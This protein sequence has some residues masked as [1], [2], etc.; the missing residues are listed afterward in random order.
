MGKRASGD[1]IISRK[2]LSKGILDAKSEKVQCHGDKKNR[3]YASVDLPSNKYLTPHHVYSSVQPEISSTLYTLIQQQQK[4][5]P[6]L[7]TIKE[8][9]YMPENNNFGP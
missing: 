8:E 4:K 5:F 9:E 6:P 7:S 1:S 3:R 2:Y